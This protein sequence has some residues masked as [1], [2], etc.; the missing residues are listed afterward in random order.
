MGRKPRIANAVTAELAQRVSVADKPAEY[1]VALET[2]TPDMRAAVEYIGNAFETIQETSLRSFWKIGRMLEQVNADPERYLTDEQRMSGVSSYGVLV[3]IFA[4]VYS[5][6]QLR[7]AL[8]F[9]TAYPT[10]QDIDR[11]IQMRCPERPRWRMTVTHA[12]LLAQVSDPDKREALENQCAADAYT[13]R[14]LAL[15]L[16]EL[17]GK[18]NQTGRKHRSPRGIKQQLLDLLEHQRKFIAR[19]EKLWLAEDAEETVYDT[20]INTPP[21]EI[22]ATLTAYFH[23]I[24]ENFDAMLSLI[25]IHK[26]LC[27]KID[28]ELF[29][30][31]NSSDEEAE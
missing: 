14:S 11:L 4:P 29:S 5:A 8:S 16:Q 25:T 13:A 21:A 12:Q 7:Q 31:E 18:G 24:S 9:Y 30:D 27:V 10:E 22:D 23:E 3:S 26:R 28:Q 15:E 19:S 17:R 20:F 6:E 1:N 2:L